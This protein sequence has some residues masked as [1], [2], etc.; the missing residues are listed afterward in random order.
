MLHIEQMSVGSQMRSIRMSGRGSLDG[1][2]EMIN[3]V[4]DTADK[5]G[6]DIS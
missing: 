4:D 2:V 3:E 6:D 5:R 1:L